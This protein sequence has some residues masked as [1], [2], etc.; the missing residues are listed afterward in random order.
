MRVVE[1]HHQHCQK[2]SAVG[3]SRALLNF[4]KR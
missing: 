2:K 1:R 4:V 3:A